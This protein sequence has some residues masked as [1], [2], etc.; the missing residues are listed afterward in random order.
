V[1]RPIGATATW[2][3]GDTQLL[4]RDIPVQIFPVGQYYL[5]APYH[6]Y[7][8][9]TYHTI[10]S[11]IRVLSYHFTSLEASRL[12]LGPQFVKMSEATPDVLAKMAIF[13]SIGSIEMGDP[14]DEATQNGDRIY[15]E[16]E[17]FE[18]Y[19]IKLTKA[20]FG[21]CTLGTPFLVFNSILPIA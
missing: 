11:S 18:L 16:E 17:L 1:P 2:S 9:Y 3:G 20:P 6:T 19:V 4:F 7:D 12:T 8:Y 15:T 10:W 5:I 21:E 13:P 14:D